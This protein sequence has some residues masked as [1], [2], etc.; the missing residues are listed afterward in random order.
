MHIHCKTNLKINTYRPGLG[1][2]IDALNYLLGSIAVNTS[3]SHTIAKNLSQRKPFS[4]TIPMK[5]ATKR[6]FNAIENF[7]QV[8]NRDRTI[9]FCSK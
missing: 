3:I 1:N 7:F 6:K 4:Y 5:T 8:F 2:I 9:K